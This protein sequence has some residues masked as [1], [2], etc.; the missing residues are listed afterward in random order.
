M[1]SEFIKE[2]N[3]EIFKL[4]DGNPLIIKALEG[5]PIGEYES[6]L[7]TY[8]IVNQKQTKSEEPE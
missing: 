1:F 6:H 3:I 5:M 4:A 7:V 8:L 2:K